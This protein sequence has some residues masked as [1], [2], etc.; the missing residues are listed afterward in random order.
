M[1]TYPLVVHVEQLSGSFAIRT[2]P[3]SSLTL[4]LRANVPFTAELAELINDLAVQRAEMA[5]RVRPAEEPTRSQRVVPKRGG[6][7]LPGTGKSILLHR[8]AA[9]ACRDGR[10][11]LVASQS[12]TAV[13]LMLDML[14]LPHPVLPPQR[15][16]EAR[17]RSDPPP[18]IEAELDEPPSAVVEQEPAV[19]GRQVRRVATARPP[20]RPM[21]RKRSRIA[22]LAPTALLSIAV[23]LAGSLW[24]D[25]SY[26]VDHGDGRYG[27][28]IASGR[29]LFYPAVSELPV[30]PR[31]TPSHI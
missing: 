18:V 22:A 30:L 15:A 13:Y 27:M 26:D 31:A 29:I 10:R 28:E 14:Q 3:D 21:P 24:V 9:D 5:R 7:T 1:S 11:V 19:E 25:V 23:W 16:G 2:N 8:V 17:P 6:S 20:R 12:P 4:L